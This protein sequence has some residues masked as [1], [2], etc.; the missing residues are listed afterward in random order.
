VGAYKQARHYSDEAA[1]FMNGLLIRDYLTQGLGNN[2]M[3]F[4]EQYY[5]SY[6]KLR[7]ECGRPYSM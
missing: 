4:A 7:P 2:P 6:P 1:H 3:H 5:L